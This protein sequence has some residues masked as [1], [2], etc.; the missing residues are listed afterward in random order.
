MIVLFQENVQLRQD[1]LKRTLYWTK[2]E[3]KCEML[4]A[5]G[6]L[7]FGLLCVFWPPPVFVA[8]CIVAPDTRL[9]LSICFCSSLE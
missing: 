2:Q 4:I 3:G 1:F 6:R 8:L 5:G 7:S 9:L